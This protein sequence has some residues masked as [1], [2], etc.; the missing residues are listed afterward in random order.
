MAIIAA[1]LANIRVKV[2]NI[3]P[4]PAAK[5]SYLKKVANKSRKLTIKIKIWLIKI[6]VAIIVADLSNID[7]N[8]ANTGSSFYLF[9][10]LRLDGMLNSRYMN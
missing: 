4:W 7:H 3:Q 8:L 5:V 1:D 2:A 10:E 6:K 9:Q